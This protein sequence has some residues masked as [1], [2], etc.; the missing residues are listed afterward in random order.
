[1]REGNRVPGVLAYA[2]GTMAAEESEILGV[3]GRAIL[4][5]V[6]D[7]WSAPAHMAALAKGRCRWPLLL[8]WM[9]HMTP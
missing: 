4:P 7:G 9:N 8:A 5:V 6:L 1:M 3:S 2:I